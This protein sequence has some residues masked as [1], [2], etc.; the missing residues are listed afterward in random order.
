MAGLE[1]VDLDKFAAQI[2]RV[3]AAVQPLA[4]EMQKEANGFSAFPARIQKLITQN[5]KLRNSNN[6]LCQSLTAY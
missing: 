6:R 1:S 5:E 4:T 3:T 2:Q